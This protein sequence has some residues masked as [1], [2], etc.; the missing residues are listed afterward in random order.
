MWIA[1][2]VS[3]ISIGLMVYTNAEALYVASPILI[4]WLFAPALAWRL[5]KEETEKKPSSPEAQNLFLHK[6]A[7]R[8]WSFFEQF[9]TEEEN[10]LPPDNFQEQPSPIIAHRTSPTNMGL[11]LLA[12]LAAF[13]FGY[14]TGGNGCTM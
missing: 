7:R 11:A 3:I 1:P 12:N 5:S 6:S 8:T 4:L 13:D 10:W 9:V 2:L 14:I